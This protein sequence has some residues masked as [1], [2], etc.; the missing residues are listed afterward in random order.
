MF[1]L[2][3]TLGQGINGIVRMHRNGGLGNQRAAIKLFGDEMNGAAVFAIAGFQGAGMGI[4]SAIFGQQGRV[5]VDQAPGVMADKHGRKNAH[6]AGEH[7]GIRGV[8]GEHL[9]HGL[10]ELLP[11]RV[12]AVIQAGGGDARLCGPLEA[13]G[14]GAIGKHHGNLGVEG[15]CFLGIHD[16]LQ[17]GA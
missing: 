10:V 5:D 14:V 17:V 3:Y 8:G 4:Q 15:T 13:G 11:V 7:H 2:L 9:D 6:E 16:R 1:A 12:V